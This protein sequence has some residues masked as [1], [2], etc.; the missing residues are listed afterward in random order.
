M[1]DGG[2]AADLCTRKIQKKNKTSDQENCEG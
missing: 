1:S 2:F